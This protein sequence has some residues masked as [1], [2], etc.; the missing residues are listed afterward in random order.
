MED[1]RVLCTGTSENKKPQQ[2]QQPQH[3][4]NCGSYCHFSGSSQP[5]LKLKLHRQ[6]TWYVQH[7]FLKDLCFLEACCKC[8]RKETKFHMW[9]WIFLLFIVT[10]SISVRFFRFLHHSSTNIVVFI[11]LGSSLFQEFILGWSIKHWITGNFS[12]VCPSVPSPLAFVSEQALWTIK[13]V[14]YWS[15]TL[16]HILYH[17]SPSVKIATLFSGSAS[18]EWFLCSLVVLRY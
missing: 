10:R 14:D 3:Q 18:M 8:Y 11:D 13:L 15:S 16:V 17:L 5:V 12:A 2:Q 6:R 1:A 9:K 4:Q 7:R